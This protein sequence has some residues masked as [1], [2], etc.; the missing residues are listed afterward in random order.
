VSYPH[1]WGHS[2]GWSTAA[3]QQGININVLI[4]ND[5]ETKDRL[6]GMSLLDGV[7]VSVSAVR[8]PVQG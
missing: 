6:S 4:P 3:A 2:G 5:L 1:G 8:A 7:P